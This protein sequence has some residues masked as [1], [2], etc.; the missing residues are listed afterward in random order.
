MIEGLADF[1]ELQL[2][3]MA[4]VI[5]AS[6]LKRV[7]D[8]LISIVGLIGAVPFFLLIPFGIVLSSRG[9]VLFVHKRY[10]KGGQPFHMYKFRT[11]VLGAD[12]E[13][14]SLASLNEMSGPAFKIK[15]DPRIYPLGKWLRKFSLDELPQLWNV[16]K[17]DM[18]LV[19][20]RPFLPGDERLFK[21]WHY[22]RHF[23][24]PGVTSYWQ[25]MGRNEIT[26]FDQ[27]AML[28]LKYIQSWTIW[29]DIKII[30]KTPLVVL[31][32][33]GH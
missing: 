3:K 15:N 32:G 14:D 9:P 26:D 30:L 29:E 17:G 16:L 28:D 33:T 19:G 27:W 13:R 31:R 6:T 25:L 18:S 23:V 5:N 7:F 8:V 11:M 20:P 24:K 2:R 22:Y 21:S 10:G 12:Q 4:D 1:D